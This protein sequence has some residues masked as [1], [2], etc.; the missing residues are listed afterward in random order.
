[1]KIYVEKQI[2]MREKKKK[3]NTWYIYLYK[4]IEKKIVGGKK[5]GINGYSIRLHCFVDNCVSPSVTDLIKC[6]P[7]KITALSVYVYIRISVVVFFLFLK[8]RSALSAF[9]LFRKYQ[10]E[11]L[12]SK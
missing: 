9:V 1:M 2:K 11:V 3:K 7:L 10:I 12:I 6:L 8:M 4:A 5:I